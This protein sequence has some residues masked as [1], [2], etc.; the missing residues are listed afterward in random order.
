MGGQDYAHDLR[1]CRVNTQPMGCVHCK[2]SPDVEEIHQEDM[3]SGPQYHDD[4]STYY[5]SE[6]EPE[7][8]V[9]IPQGSMDGKVLFFWASDHA[10]Q[11]PEDAKADPLQLPGG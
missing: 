5:E 2:R 3:T 9:P 4:W 6:D 8:V 7:T 11:I 10:D 1:A